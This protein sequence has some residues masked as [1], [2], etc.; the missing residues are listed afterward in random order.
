MENYC[1]IFG[2]P[3]SLGFEPGDVGVWGVAFRDQGL[4]SRSRL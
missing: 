2:L 1:R 3:N 4:R